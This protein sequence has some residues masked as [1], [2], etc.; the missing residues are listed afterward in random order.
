M[1]AIKEIVKIVG[2]A[3][4]M[5]GLLAGMASAQDPSDGLVPMVRV[6]VPNLSPNSAKIMPPSFEVGVMGQDEDSATGLPVKY[7]ILLVT[8]EYDTTETGEPLYIR[9]PFEYNL[10]GA[11]LLFWD[12]QG[13]SDW[14]DYPAEGG[15]PF[16]SFPDLA[17]QVYYLLALQVMDSDG[18]VSIALDY[19]K[20]VF[21]FQVREGY[22]RPD[23]TICEPFLGCPNASEIYNEIAGGQPLN[24]SWIADAG[25]YGGTIVSYRHGWDLVDPD[26]SNDP[27]WAVPPGLEPENLF[28]Q[29]RSFSEGLHNF[30]LRVVDDSGQVRNISWSL[31]VVPFV[32]PNY[33]FPLLV[34]DQIYD[35]DGLI[36]NWP[37]QDG[38]PRNA[39]RYRNPY[40]QFLEDVSGGVSGVDWSR[41][42]MDHRDTPMFRDLVQ[43]KAVLCYAKSN[44]ANQTMCQQFRPV[45]G[46]DRYVW[47]AP[48]QQNGGNY[49]QVGGSS[50]ESFLEGL[51]NYMVPII[52]DTNETLS[53][54]TKAP[55]G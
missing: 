54:L 23:V 37:D 44:D 40:W 15:M 41:D 2:G 43:Y 34:I 10:H 21:N 18:S 17:D 50:M 24:F 38:N 11:E 55:I 51:T 30:H 6:A 32:D 28:A 27:G 9:T 47:L 8:A 42:W 31:S 35:P 22:F 14:T 5:M 46:Q 19:Q 26:D 45:N 1:K 12:H 4:L 39:E 53:R 48:Y 3:I 49:F 16:I 25:A 33:Q 13:W 29:E 52:F 7:R 36:N 20:E